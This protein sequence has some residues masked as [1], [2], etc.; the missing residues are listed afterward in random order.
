M[1]TK[2]FYFISFFLIMAIIL[3]SVTVFYYVRYP[4][5][6]NAEIIRYSND[7]NLDPTLV[8]SLINVESSFNTNA[9]S[10]SGAIGLMQIM[11]QTGNFVAEMFKESFNEQNLYDVKT[12]IKYG[13]RYL[14]YLKDKFNNNKTMLYAYNAGEG[15]VNL[16]LKNK[17]YSN[18]GVTLHDVPYKVTNEYV[19]K[20]LA[21]QKYYQNR[22]K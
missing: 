3:C 11:P 4:I 15:S 1:K 2:P 7:N 14:K 8:A 17:D 6:Y 19:E 12:N 5:K 20:I 9:K 18:D 22:I 10:S 21:G 13:C 16:W